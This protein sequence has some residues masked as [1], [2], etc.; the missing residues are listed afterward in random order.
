[1]KTDRHIATRL[2]AAL[3]CASVGC[4]WVVPQAFA[5]SDVGFIS[6]VRGRPK[7]QDLQGRWAPVRLM[8]TL[9]TGETLALQKND[10]IGICHERASKA[11]R[12]EG[13]GTFLLDKTGIAQQTG[14]L[15]V[16]QTGA[17]GQSSSPRE[18]G[19][20]LLRSVK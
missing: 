14:A 6:S 8:Q 18:T 13:T 20:V 1:M 4:V 15:K 7:S 12:V 10:A 3:A 5:A 19:G 11:Y 16:T 2:I 17:C 9:F